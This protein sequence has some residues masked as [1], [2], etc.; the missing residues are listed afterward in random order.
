MEISATLDRIVSKLYVVSSDQ[1]PSGVDKIR[2]TF[3]E[4]GK[5]FN[6]STGLAISN[7]GFSNTVN[8]SSEVGHRTGTISYLFLNT[9]EQTM[10]I[11]IDAL[12]AN[13][14][15]VY[16]KTVRN[17]P[18]KVNRSTRLDGKVYTETLPGSTS[19]QVNDEWLTET[20]VSF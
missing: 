17:V 11:T 12:D 1:R 2:T 4:G 18:F 15:V 19:F 13:D 7:T 14:H 16:S 5:S 8:I 9:A 6:P 3:S 20:T 10:D